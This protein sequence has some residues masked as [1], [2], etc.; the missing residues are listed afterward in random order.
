MIDRQVDGIVLA[1]MYTRKL[2]VPKAFATTPAVLL[3][4]LPERPSIVSGRSQRDQA[5][6]HAAQI[7]LDAGHRE[8]IYLIGGGP[9]S[10]QVP[11][12]AL[13]ATERYKG[14]KKAFVQAGAAIAGAVEC[15]EWEP[16]TGYQALRLLLEEKS[17]PIEAAICSQRPAR[18][19]RKSRATGKAGLRIPD[20]VSVVSFDDDPLATWVRP[21]LTTV[22]LP[23]Y[24]LGQT[25]LNVLFGG[26]ER[27]EVKPAAQ[28]HRITMPVRT[29]DSVRAIQD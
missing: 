29:R 8:E 11:K 21:M 22:A 14:I 19:G 17:V 26:D 28:V 5:G 9:R 15:S 16:E 25:A 2:P 10:K 6:K 18:D 4:A 24:E 7:L 27:P 20:D 13:A 1:S 3:N 12:G 23:H